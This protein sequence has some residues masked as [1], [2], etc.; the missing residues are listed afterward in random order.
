[1]A[2]AWPLTSAVGGVG[3][4]A[5]APTRNRARAALRRTCAYGRATTAY[6]ACSMQ[7][8]A[9]ANAVCLMDVG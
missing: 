8:I 7:A 9:I 5:T 4:R 6:G 3:G 2:R 1:M